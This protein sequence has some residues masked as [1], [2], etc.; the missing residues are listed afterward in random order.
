MARLTGFCL[1]AALLGICLA[2]EDAEHLKKIR[3]LCLK[4]LEKVKP[5]TDEEHLKHGTG[6]YT[7]MLAGHPDLRH[8][9]IG[10][11][12]YTEEQIEKSAFF[13]KQGQKILTSIHMLANSYDN[14][15]AFKAYTRDVVDRHERINVELESKLWKEFWDIFLEFLAKHETV[16]DE[17]KAAWHELGTKFSEEAVKHHHIDHE[18]LKHEREILMKSLH[19]V[20]PGLNAHGIQNGLDLYKVMLGGH[21]NLRKYFKG[22]EHFTPDDIQKSIF[23]KKQ[24]QRLL[25]AVHVLA[26]SYD[27][28]DTFRAYIRDLLERHERI[29][30]HLEADVWKMFFDEILL[31]F[32]AKKETV[33]DEEKKAWHELGH[34]FVDETL[35]YLVFKKNG[36]NITANY[37]NDKGDSSS[38][39]RNH[40]KLES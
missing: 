30:V 15:A 27:C 17:T 34:H 14:P 18:H 24:G 4:S 37:Q 20:E 16:D 3:H 31:E 38:K 25:V 40:R 5:G 29:D 13:K 11:E 28:P 32:L 12:N 8:Y 35:D 33:S 23:F 9:F 22:K 21:P 10:H 2:T 7:T 26:A 19:K 1:L 6:I 36:S 39:Q